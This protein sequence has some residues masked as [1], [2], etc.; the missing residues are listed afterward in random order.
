MEKEDLTKKGYKTTV[1]PDEDIARHTDVLLKYNG[2]V[3]RIWLYQFSFAGL[4]HDIERI[5]G[6]RGE[7]P[8]GNHVLCPLNTD[9]ARRLEV[10][11]KR[12][13]WL[14]K[15]LKSKQTNFE[16]YYNKNCKGALDCLSVSDQLREGIKV[17]LSE[18]E[19]I[20]DH[21]I[22]IQNGWYFFAETKVKSVLNRIREI[23]EDK[24]KADNYRNVCR[25]L[26]GP[27]EYLGKLQVFSKSE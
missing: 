25:I 26:I 12:K 11:E 10:L 7:L 2:S 4:P 16:K 22:V 6:R 13:N 3:F 9:L 8:P 24:S 27:E 21:E 23:S 20:R 1:A 14:E 5:L 15:R 19:E 17:A 18:I